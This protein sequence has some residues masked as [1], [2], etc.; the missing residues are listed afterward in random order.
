VFPST[1]S[2]RRA[3]NREAEWCAQLMSRNDPWITL[4]RNLEQCRLRCFHPDWEL[5]VACNPQ[6]DL[7]GFLLLNPQGFIGFPYIASICVDEGFRNHGLGKALIDYVSVQLG[8][9]RKFLFLCVSSFNERARSFY[10]RIGFQPVGILKD[11]VVDGLDE[12]LLIK[13]LDETIR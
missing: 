8:P 10:L 5:Y 12:C 11:F 9:Q 6:G 4:G 7:G 13:R 3:Q 2:I 1:W